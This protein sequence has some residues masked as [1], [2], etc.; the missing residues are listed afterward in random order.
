[1]KRVI[2]ILCLLGLK[3]SANAQQE[4]N[5]DDD[6]E[7]ATINDPDGFANLRKAPNSNAE[8]VGKV[9][10]YNIFSCESTKTNWWK[11]LCIQPDNHTK[12]Y[13]LEGYIYKSRVLLLSDWKGINKRGGLAVI[14][15]KTPF[16]PQKHKLFYT[17]ED[18][19]NTRSELRKLTVNFFGELMERFPRR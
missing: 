11:V 10:K 18:P 19:N 15:K 7:Y 4:F 16:N 8:I 9:Y 2:L 17:K 6:L 1:M 3:F 13:W 5:F 12:S 14:V